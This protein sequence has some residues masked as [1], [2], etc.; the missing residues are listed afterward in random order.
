MI[1]WRVG[2]LIEQ[3]SNRSLSSREVLPYALAS[4]IL[5][6]LVFVAADWLRPWDRDEFEATID[7]ATT[8]LAGVISAFGVW[9]C[10]RANGT[11][12]GVELVDRLLTIGFVVFV[13]FVVVC[14]IAS[15]VWIYVAVSFKFDFRPTFE[16]LDLLFVFVVALFWYRL[17]R[18]VRS[19]AHARAI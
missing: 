14:S 6:S 1:I 5:A 3:M 11:T 10:Y 13:R 12:H 18:H 16:D 15:V 4:A 8:L 2:R 9:A 7:S 17:Q 19:V